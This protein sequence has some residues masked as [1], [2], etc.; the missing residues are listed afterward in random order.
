MRDRSWNRGR[1]RVW[2]EG[3]RE[4]RGWRE[5][6]G[7]RERGCDRGERGEGGERGVVTGKRKEKLERDKI[8]PS[9]CWSVRQ[10]P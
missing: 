9:S 6:R 4:R 10:Q 7:G 3:G 2:W 5:G 8:F 1:L